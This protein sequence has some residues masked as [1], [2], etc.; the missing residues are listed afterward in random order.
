MMILMIIVNNL[1]GIEHILMGFR[2]PD[3]DPHGYCEQSHE[4]WVHS[5]GILGLQMMILVVIVNSLMR[6]ECI[7]M[8]I[9][10]VL[11]GI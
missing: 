6:V 2:P 4:D 5:H 11:M 7:L 1:M 10:H 8:G 9:K 3:D